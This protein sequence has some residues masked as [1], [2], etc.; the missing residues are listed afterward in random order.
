VN[1]TLGMEA[2]PLAEGQCEQRKKQTKS[3]GTILNVACDGLKGG[4]Q[5]CPQSQ[6]RFYVIFLCCD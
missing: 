3:S 1:K 6:P 4:G 5:D 2:Q